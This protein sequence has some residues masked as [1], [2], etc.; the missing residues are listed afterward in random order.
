MPQNPLT[1]RVLRQTPIR[2]AYGL[3]GLL[4]EL[5]SAKFS[6]KNFDKTP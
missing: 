4:T 1:E 2:A 5:D 3:K 6:G